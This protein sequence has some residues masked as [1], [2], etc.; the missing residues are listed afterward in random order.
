MCFIIRKQISILNQ[1]VFAHDHIG[2]NFLKILT[3]QTIYKWIYL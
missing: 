2:D 3:S 1:A